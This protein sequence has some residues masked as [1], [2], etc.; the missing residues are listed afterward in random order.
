MRD[1]GDGKGRGRVQ[2][3]LFESIVGEQKKKRRK[4]RRER[5]REMEKERAFS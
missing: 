4:R 5:E 2:K 1:T 3:L